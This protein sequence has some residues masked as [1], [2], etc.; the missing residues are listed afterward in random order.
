MYSLALR[1]A[2]SYD[3]IEILKYIIEERGVIEP[4]IIYDAVFEE[5]VEVLRYL[6][7]RGIRWNL[8]DLL[9][10]Q[11]GRFPPSDPEIANLL[12]FSDSEALF[13]AIFP[14]EGQDSEGEGDWQEEDD[15]RVDD[16]LLDNVDPVEGI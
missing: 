12:G 16:P 11:R 1:A 15:N 10:A 6:L 9:E 4:S 5:S 3:R 13:Q 8:A 14:L 2:A 7:S